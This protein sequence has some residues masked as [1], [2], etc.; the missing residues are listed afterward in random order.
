MQRTKY[1]RVLCRAFLLACALITTRSANAQSGAKDSKEPAIVAGRITLE[2]RGVAGVLVT[3]MSSQYG[4]QVRPTAK[5]TT[6]AEGRYRMT[7]VPAGSYFLNPFAP[8]YVVSGVNPSEWQPGRRLD[9]APGEKLESLD[10][11][12]ERGGVVTGRVTD[13]EGRP[14]VEAMVRVMAAD[15][16]DRKKPRFAVPMFAFETDDR[17]VYR[18]Y[19]LAPGRYLIYVG[20]AQEDG[21]VRVG[22]GGYFPRTF[23]GDTSEINQAK[24]VEV[25][26]GD[27]T[28][29]IDIKLGKPAKT[30]AASGRVVDEQGQPVAGASIMFGRVSA[31][32]RFSGGFGADGTKANERGEF[33]LNNLPPGR[34]GLFAARDEAFSQQQPT[35][36][37]EAALA[38]IVDEDVSGLEVKLVRGATITGVVTL[39]GA[40]SPA[41]LAKL[42]ELSIAAGGA[43]PALAPPSFAQAHVQADGSFQLTGLR[44]GKVTLALGWPQVKGFTIA[45]VQRDGVDQVEGIDV[46]A[47]DHVAGVR[48][49]VTYGTSTIRGQVE[50]PG[51]RPEGGYIHVEAYR[52]GAPANSQSGYAEIDA[53]GRFVLANLPAGEYELRLFAEGQTFGS[54]QRPSPVDRKVVNVTEGVETQ[55]TLTYRQAAPQ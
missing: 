50:F 16:A 48:V 32:N 3:L 9:L 7:D 35:D 40:S 39:E 19:G 34:Y 30:Y 54:A 52:T 49:V 41:V 25:K 17:G 37:S 36:Y 15:E 47:G 6:D 13:P 29:G 11:T 4:Q 33:K 20:E 22:V 12:L 8:A 38:E 53:L 42:S 26:P 46:A 10:F 31:E 14:L 45:R 21:I 2:G 24:P 27:E 5:A 18:L 51:G 23:Y 28:A 55:V 43:A 1:R 44:P